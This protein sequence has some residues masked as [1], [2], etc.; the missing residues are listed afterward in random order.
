[1]ERGIEEVQNGKD[2]SEQWYY[3]NPDIFHRCSC[4]ANTVKSSTEKKYFFLIVV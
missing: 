4:K 3:I 2:I 1:M